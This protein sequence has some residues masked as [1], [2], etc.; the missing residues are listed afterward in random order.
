M[1]G[2][3]ERRKEKV[4]EK[5]IELLL[6]WCSVMPSTNYIFAAVLIQFT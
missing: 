2:K 6:S 1:E 5:E 4:K 3:K